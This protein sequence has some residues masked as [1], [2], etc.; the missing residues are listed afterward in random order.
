MAMKLTVL[1]QVFRN[2]FSSRKEPPFLIAK[3]SPTMQ[4]TDAEVVSAPIICPTCQANWADARIALGRSITPSDFQVKPEFRAIAKIKEES[5][6]TCPNCGY[7]YTEW[8]I[9][10]TV[11]AALN[12]Q[13]LQRQTDRSFLRRKEQ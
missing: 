2:L 4:V 8:A 12:R 9:L 6:L 3:R 10:A 7:E 11:I 13:E 5:P 1:W